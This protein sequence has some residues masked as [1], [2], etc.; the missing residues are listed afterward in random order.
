MIYLGDNC[1][2]KEGENNG[3]LQEKNYQAEDHKE[4]DETLISFG[5][6]D[7]VSYV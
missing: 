1:F 2:I 4:K 7:T 5:F 6:S 3:L